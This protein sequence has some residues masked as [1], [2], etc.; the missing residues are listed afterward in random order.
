MII[1]KEFFFIRHGKIDDNAS[2]AKVDH[3]DVSLNAMGIQQARAIAP[4]IASLP[5]K[6]VCCSPFKRA[7]ET[8]EIIT[9]CIHVQHHEIPEIGECSAQI[10]NDM[11][12]CGKNTINSPHKHVKIFIQK[13]LHGVNQAL[14]HEG[15]V[16]LVSHGGIH[17]VICCLMNIPGHEWII[18]NCQPVHF[19]CRADG[20][21]EARKLLE[22]L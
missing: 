16:L 10:W 9:S 22:K 13:A 17:W 21:W 4:V 1:K 15:P 20:H 11:T 18:G 6:S 7:K 2:N 3:G 12:A 19:F 8:A 14:A 5:L